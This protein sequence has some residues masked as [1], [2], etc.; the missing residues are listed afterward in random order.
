MIAGEELEL[1][2]KSLQ[3]ATA[4]HTGAE[5]DAALAELGWHD[6]LAVDRR[7]AVSTLFEL[8]GAAN[9]TSSALDLVLLDALGAGVAPGARVVLPRLGA[10]EVPGALDGDALSVRGLT[11]SAPGAAGAVV[12]ASDASGDDIAVEVETKVLACRSVPGLDPMLGMVEV[13]GDRVRATTRLDPP[14]AAWSDAVAAGQLAVAHQLVGASRTM[15]RL[16][17]DHAV[18]RVQFG[19]P[20]ASFQAVRHRLAESLVATE[21]AAAACG[22]AWDEGT[23]LAAA[24]AKAIAGRA[25]L[26]VAKHAQQV[27]AGIGFTTEHPL[28]LYVRRVM[29][30]DRLLGS[31]RSLTAEVG[32]Q[33][34]A[35][36]RLPN[37]LPL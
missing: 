27:L 10:A 31:S 22:A 21:G 17:R 2:A 32:R 8:Q 9:A 28:H 5:L 25:A 34:L 36:R 13:A 29:V 20:I 11:T 1:F 30:L 18:E 37:V 16:A 12:I 6:A 33:L 4:S 19:S 7:A 24:L 35:Q 26:T 23:P 14:P 3:R 15:L